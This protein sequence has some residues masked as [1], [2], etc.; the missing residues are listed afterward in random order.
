MFFYEDLNLKYCTC[1]IFRTLCQRLLLT[2]STSFK[3]SKLYLEIKL[4]SDD[5]MLTCW[6]QWRVMY[7]TRFN[8]NYVLQMFSNAPSIV[9]L[10][11]LAP[12]HCVAV[13]RHLFRSTGELSG[14]SGERVEWGRVLNR[15]LNRCAADK[16][17]GQL[18]HAASALLGQLPNGRNTKSCE[19]DAK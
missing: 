3:A 10:I 8:C 13:A 15:S 14:K 5:H 12:L 4:L 17:Q 2:Y 6:R 16:E 18:T 11:L 19:G 1:L 9:E 7:G